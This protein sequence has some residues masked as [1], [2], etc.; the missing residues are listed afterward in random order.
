MICKALFLVP[1]LRNDDNY[2]LI[3][4]NNSAEMLN[5]SFFFGAARKGGESS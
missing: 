2:N 4:P 1:L 3:S 5:V